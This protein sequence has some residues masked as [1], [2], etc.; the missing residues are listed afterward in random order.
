[1]KRKVLFLIESLSGGGAEKVL[2]VILHRLDK[3]F[4]DITVC[5]I[6]DSGVFREAVKS[7]LSNYSPVICYDGGPIL[8]AFNRLKYKLVYSWLPLSW[9]YKLFIPKDHDVEIAFCEGFVTKLLSRSGSKAKKIAW[10]HTD[11]AANPWTL[12][13]GI[14]GSKEE[15]RLAYLRYDKVVCVSNVAEA[16]IRRDY[17]LDNTAV[18]YNPVDSEAIHSLSRED[19]SVIMDPSCF[20]IVAVGRLVS[21]KGFDELIRIVA[22]L[23]TKNPIVQLYIVGEGCDRLRL[24]GLITG[25][26]A[27]DK[28]HLTGY[29]ANPYALMSRADLFVCPSSAEG[30]SL[31]VAEAMVLGI[32]IVSI[33]SAGPAELLDNGRFGELCSD[34]GELSES[35]RKAVSDKEYIKD[36]RQRSGDG[37]ARF[38][39]ADSLGQIKKLFEAI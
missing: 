24:E 12:Q 39:I 1:M 32:P 28:I 6:V 29:L 22:D 34:Y 25:C 2:S 31:T 20:N 27:K 10:V 16:I 3:D 17:G 13:R 23:A 36:L 15:E 19:S 9:V 7:S 11:L 37:N 21:K 4:F 38:N 33:N 5:P 26:E 35:L 14:Y 30:F 8:R 18:I